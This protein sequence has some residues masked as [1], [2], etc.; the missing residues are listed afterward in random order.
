MPPLDERDDALE[1]GRVGAVA[2]VAV[3]VLDVDLVVLAV[4]QGLLGPRRQRLPRRVHRELEVLGERR[5]HAAGSTRRSRT[6]AP[7]ARSRPRPATEVVVGHEQLGVDLELGADAGARRARAEGRVERE[8]PRLDL[9]HGERVVVGAGHPL[10]EPALP[11]GVRVVRVH[12]D[13]VDEHD[14]AGEPERGLDRVGQPSLGAGVAA[15]GHQP[16]DDDLDRVLELL[17][18]RGGSVSETTSPSTRAREK[19]LVWSSAN[20]STY[21]PLR[22]WTTGAS[23]WNRVRSGSSSSRSTICWGVCRVT[24]LAADRA[25]RAAGAGEEQAEVVV[26]LGDRAD[27]RPRVAVGRLLVDRDGRRQPLDEVDVGLVHLPEELA[28]IRADSDST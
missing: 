4:E 14:A 6:P 7:R 8:R 26:D 1:A 25:V 21:S 27:G 13:E 11:N 2:A 10:R 17:L 12:V 23:T 16:V 9:V 15:L 20:R 22:P 18:Q 19:P 3:A 24:G 28:R 5:D